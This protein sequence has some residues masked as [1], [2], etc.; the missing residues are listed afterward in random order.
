MNMFG[1]SGIMKVFCGILVIVLS[2]A[3]ISRSQDKKEAI[4]EEVASYLDAVFESSLAVENYD[5]TITNW[6]GW[7]PHLQGF[8]EQEIKWRMIMDMKNERCL[9]LKTVVKTDEKGKRTVDAPFGY[10]YSDGM[11]TTLVDAEIA[12]RFAKMSFGEFLMRGVPLPN[13]LQFSRFPAPYMGKSPEEYKRNIK[14]P[15][16]GAKAKVLPGGEIEL[17]NDRSRARINASNFSVTSVVYF[18]GKKERGKVENKYEEKDGV[19]R[20]VSQTGSGRA[21]QNTDEIG[22]TE[23]TWHRFN[24][25]VLEFPKIEDVTKDQVAMLRFI[26]KEKE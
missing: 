7:R 11:V 9:F 26:N 22:R 10:S 24:E 12:D 23:I 17:S 4:D 1:K 13:A 8:V 18:D 15:F 14:V 19:A 2:L 6:R 5:V 20:L 25:K 21:P 16:T 3:A